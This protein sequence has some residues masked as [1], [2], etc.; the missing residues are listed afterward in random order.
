MVS[1]YGRHHWTM[2]RTW[3]LPMVGT[4]ELWHLAAS[5]PL[6]IWYCAISFTNYR[7]RLMQEGAQRLLTWSS[8]YSL[9]HLH[10]IFLLDKILIGS[11]PS[12][13]LA[14][15]VHALVAWVLNHTLKLLVLSKHTPVLQ[16]LMLPK[17]WVS[18][19]ASVM[20]HIESSI[21]PYMTFNNT[22]LYITHPKIFSSPT[23]NSYNSH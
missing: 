3:C 7:V 2:Y 16:C 22:L 5:Q 17:P 9:V 6:L 1:T 13:N 20:W 21:I 11:S 12:F 19:E 8:Q 14:I 4:T 10:R 23:P 18:I 15:Q